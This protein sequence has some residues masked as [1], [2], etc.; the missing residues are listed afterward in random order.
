MILLIYNYDSFSYNLYQLIGEIQQ[1][2]RVVR[3]DDV[4]ISDIEQMQPS[5]IIISPGPG[6]P[7]DAGICEEAIKHFAGRIPMLGVCLGH[8]AICETYGATVGS[9][10]ELVH[11]KQYEIVI[12][13]DN[14]IF[15]GLP[16]TIKV[17]RYHS[18]AVWADTIP[19]T[20]QVI[21]QTIDGE[22]M[23]VCH[24]IHKIYGL[25]FHP[26]SILTP[27]GRTIIRNF[28]EL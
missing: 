19:E 1:D 16:D 7:S 10:K 22:V 27:D 9:A 6:K 14:P 12:N 15:A 3:N 18:L 23:A 5:H 24:T 2:I 4:T 11:G 20:L 26:E 21:A 13:Q 8:Q 28:L 17:A 25:Q